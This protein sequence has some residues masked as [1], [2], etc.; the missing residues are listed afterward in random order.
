MR[1]DDLRWPDVDAALGKSTPV[2]LPLGSLEQHGP[3]LPF[4][5]DT[6][7]VQA[8][9]D[10]ACEQTEA[11]SLPA[12]SYG[13]PSRPRS[14]G[15]PVFPLGA[16]IPLGTYFDVVRGVMV[17]LL[18]RGVR[19][20]VVMS[21]HTENGVVIY[22]AAREAVSATGTDAKIVAIDSPGGFIERETAEKAFV[23]G[24]VPGHFEHAG[25]IETSVM[26][27][28]QPDRVAEFSDVQASLPTLPYDVV[29]QPDGAV[30]PTGSFTSP[31][32]ATAEIGQL[33]LDDILPG[34][35]RAVEQEFSA[36]R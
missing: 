26:L 1:L 7:C 21:W 13:A 36:R 31:K 20:L 6:V 5:T 27:A 32:N 22:D 12:L 8:V 10:G 19:N 28:L 2:I 16:E 34:L 24:P 18:E 15:G 3:H 9:S 14:G 33:L 30:S 23:D 11:I 35:A 29:P 25:L 17:N 4:D